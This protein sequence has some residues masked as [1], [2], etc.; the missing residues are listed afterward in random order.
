MDNIGHKD[1]LFIIN[2][3]SGG[4]RTRWIP[5]KLREK[6][7]DVAFHVTKDVNES[8]KI[9][10]RNIDKYKLFIL[11]GGD[12][13]INSA[14]NHFY[15]NKKVILGVLPTGSG[16]GFARELG[17]GKSLKGLF[18]NISKG[19]SLDIDV[20]SVNGRLCINA[21]GLG[22]DSYV[23]HTFHQQAGRGL[24]NYILS[25]LKSMLFFRPF[26]ASIQLG[27]RKIEG[28][29]F[30][31]TFANTRQFGNNAIISPGSKPNDGIVELILVKPFPVYLYPI[32]VLRLFTGTLEKS[33]YIRALK[34][35]SKVEIRSDYIK[36][37]VDGE[38]E[39][40]EGLL[41]VEM[42]PGKVRVLKTEVFS[43]TGN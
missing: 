1:I 4:N 22:F 31:I 36:Y 6:Y 24:K 26:R 9:Y 17:F 5:G 41:S 42:K 43:G 29:Y 16:N 34:M 32:M 10:R 13:T 14:L 19:E 18:H 30:M 15:D 37:H 40:S 33:H 12:G 7:P 38:P 27:N 2:P 3:K 21:T 11:V 39:F 25:T 8:D 20:L 28:R 23:A 35:T